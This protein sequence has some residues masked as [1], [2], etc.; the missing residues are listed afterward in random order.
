MLKIEP[1]LRKYDAFVIAAGSRVRDARDTMAYRTK[2]I[3]L[4]Q[5]ELLTKAIESM[6]H[7]GSSDSFG[8]KH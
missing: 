8:L 4:T 2:N 3:F 1:H 7:R 6:Q 5:E